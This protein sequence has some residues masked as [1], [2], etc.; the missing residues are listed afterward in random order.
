VRVP[1]CVEKRVPITRT[2][3]V[4]RVICCR[5]P[6]DPCGVPIDTCAPAAELSAPVEEPTY[7]PTEEPTRAAP[8]EETPQAT[9]TPQ[10]PSGDGAAEEV[11]KL[12][13]VPIP[14]PLDAD[15]EEPAPSGTGT[16]SGTG[17]E[18]FEP[19]SGT[20]AYRPRVDLGT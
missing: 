14:R 7:G 10:E 1:R 17:T 18:L 9:E 3:C 6:L 19:G 16:D 2:Y 13:V 15:E 11:P 4:P 12:D 8:K 5:V 20:D